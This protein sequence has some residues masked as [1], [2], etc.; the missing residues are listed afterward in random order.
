[1]LFVAET[2]SPSGTLD[3]AAY[4]VLLIVPVV[5]PQGM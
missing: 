3:M 1:M 5:R 4:V 2:A